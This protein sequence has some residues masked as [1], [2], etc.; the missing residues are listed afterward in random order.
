MAGQ[1]L[2]E[3]IQVLSLKV[4]DPETLVLEITVAPGARLVPSGAPIAYG[5]K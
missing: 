3:D 4:L 1:T 5:R 2:N